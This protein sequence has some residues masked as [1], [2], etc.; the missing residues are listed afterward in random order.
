[1]RNSKTTIYTKTIAIDPDD[2]K[3]IESIKGKKSRAGKL[4]EIIHDYKSKL[5]DI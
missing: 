1:M 3:F 2:L 4:K 5:L